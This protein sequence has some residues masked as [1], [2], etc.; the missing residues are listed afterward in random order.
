M[1][2]ARLAERRKARGNATEGFRSDRHCELYQWGFTTGRPE[3]E[4]LNVL[5]RIC[6]NSVLAW[7]IQNSINRAP[8]G[9]VA[10]ERLSAHMLLYVTE[11][12]CFSPSDPRVFKSLSV[13][14]L[15]L[16]L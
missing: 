12:S 9:S 15:Y 6:F 5:R 14:I 3:A 11:Q 7:A 10:G 16:C 8:N 1:R 2:P 13:S 4:G